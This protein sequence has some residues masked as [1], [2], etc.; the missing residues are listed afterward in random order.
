MK[1]IWIVSHNANPPQFS[2]SVRHHYLTKYASKDKYNINI[3]ASSAIHNSDVNYIKKEERVKYKKTEIDGVTYI[4][5]KTS[6]YKG[7]KTS[8]IINMLQFFFNTLLLKKKLVKE[9]GKPDIIYASSPQPFSAWAGLSLSKKY[10]V[11][12]ILEIR[13]LWPESIVSF[14]VLKKNNIIIKAL[15]L[16][17]KKLYIKADKIVFTFE[18]GKDYINNTK[19]DKKVDMNKIYHLNN[20]VDLDKNE[21]NKLNNQIK[22][23]DIDNQDTFKV[24]YTGAIRHAY[25]VQK[26]V[27]VAEKIKQNN[28]SKIKVFIYGT[29]SH[30][31]ELEKECKKR[32]I[33]NVVF[34][35]FVENKYIAYITN[36][37]DLLLLHG[38]DV[39]IFKYGTSQN[40]LFSYLAGGKPIISSFYNK[41]DLIERHK[42]GETLRTDELDE[43]YD[44]VI[45]FYNM[46]KEEYNKYCENALSLSKKYDYKALSKEFIKII[47]E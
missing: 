37:C 1:N 13:D 5:I 22:D 44:K 35:G 19:Y 31:E 45:K 38:T 46:P 23:E 16:M 4:H 18:G 6:Q 11:P 10:K 29:G 26:I 33:D 28:Y 14:N 15:Y 40:K 21:Y 32:D 2:G 25:N 20:G 3:I 41:Y 12:F 36:K 47:E 24:L 43:F 27:N 7:N 30:K 8:R 9:I 42:C 17:E 34:K 39:D